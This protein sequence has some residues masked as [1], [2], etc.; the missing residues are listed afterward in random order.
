MS[1]RATRLT[2]EQITELRQRARREVGPSGRTGPFVDQRLMRHIESWWNYELCEWASE[3]T[4]RTVT[5]LR[6]LSWETWVLLN[7][8]HDA[9]PSPPPPPKL[10]A[11]REQQRLVDEERARREQAAWQEKWDEWQR[12]HAAFAN[13]GVPVSV[14]HNYASSRHYEFYE[15]GADHILVW[16]D[17]SVGRL[18]RK[19]RESLCETPSKRN[20]LLFDNDE[21][22]RKHQEEGWPSGEKE[23]AV[24]T[25]KACL[26][27]ARRVLKKGEKP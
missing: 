16:G 13:L 24:P 23:R 22:E 20:S 14:A 21:L 17:M 4:G 27:T 10:T 7:L 9:E 12:I 18:H 6:H 26:E 8:A 15:Q 11:Q 25:C 3:I 19:A 5:G 1:D 2:T